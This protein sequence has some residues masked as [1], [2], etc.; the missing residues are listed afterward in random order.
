MAKKKKY[1]DYSYHLI[2]S[3]DFNKMEDKGFTGYDRSTNGKWVVMDGGDSKVRGWVKFDTN[4]LDPY[5]VSLGIT[6]SQL[7]H[8]EA[9]ALVVTLA[10]SSGAS[11]GY[12]WGD[13]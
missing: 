5:M 9:E 4:L 2:H 8:I 1:D 12:S 10:S 7:T 6:G 11:D 13:I 3:S